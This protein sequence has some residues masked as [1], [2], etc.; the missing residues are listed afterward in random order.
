[1]TLC[2]LQI[3]NTTRI[4]D[5]TYTGDGLQWRLKGPTLPYLPGVWC[6]RRVSVVWCSVVCAVLGVT[7]LVSSA[8]D[9]TVWYGMVDVCGGWLAAEASR[10]PLELGPRVVVGMV[11]VCEGYWQRKPNH[12]HVTLH[13]AQKCV[14]SKY[15]GP[16][17]PLPT[18]HFVNVCMV[19]CY[20]HMHACMH[21]C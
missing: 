15:H 21:A 16:L 14:Q 19:A 11:D 6:S 10:C 12:T 8:R 9:I 18:A 13:V 5:H 7:C 20:I 2:T 17:W 1:M 3:G 4:L